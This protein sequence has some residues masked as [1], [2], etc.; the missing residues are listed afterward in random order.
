MHLLEGRS[1]PFR[2]TGTMRGEVGGVG[3]DR[4]NRFV[5]CS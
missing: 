1:D 2:N 5:V 4:E 3:V